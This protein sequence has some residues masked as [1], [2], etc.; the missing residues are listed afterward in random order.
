MNGGHKNRRRIYDHE[1]GYAGFVVI[2]QTA[3]R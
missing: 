2:A 3:T 1:P